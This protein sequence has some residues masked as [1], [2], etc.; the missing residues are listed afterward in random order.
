M[1]T[2][3][4]SFYVIYSEID[5]QGPYTIEQLNGWISE[6]LISESTLVWR[7]GMKS[8][9][10][11]YCIYG[12]TCYKDIGQ[13]TLD[14]GI[15]RMPYLIAYF[16]LGFALLLMFDSAMQQTR[17]FIN[18]R[19]IYATP[20]AVLAYLRLKHLSL[21]TKIAWIAFVPVIEPFLFLFC[22]IA[23]KEFKN[24][25]KLDMNGIIGIC[26]LLPF[27]LFIAFIQLLAVGQFIS[28]LK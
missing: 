21:P 8:P 6:Q 24:E 15:A 5:R 2:T 28:T 22:S 12:L 10:P 14:Y 7:Q 26:L 27:V 1:S 23:P 9:K 18:S 11:A 20:A 16:I 17:S 13:R 4:N 3:N 25:R 19:L